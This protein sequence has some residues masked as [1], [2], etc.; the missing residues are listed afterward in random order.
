[1]FSEPDAMD[2]TKTEGNA[3]VAVRHEHLSVSRP[4]D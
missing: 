3:S 4:E 2:V 1:M